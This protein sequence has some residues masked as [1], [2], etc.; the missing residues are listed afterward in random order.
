MQ[1]LIY[2]WNNEYY[3]SELFR[4]ISGHKIQFLHK[5][6]YLDLDNGKD[7]TWLDAISDNTSFEGYWN[8]FVNE[9]NWLHQYLSFVHKDY[10]PFIRKYLENLDQETLSSSEQL[11]LDYW[12]DSIVNED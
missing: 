10:K 9:E 11:Q 12:L 2:K 7:D 5:Y 3:K 6:S 8:E 4:I 1:E